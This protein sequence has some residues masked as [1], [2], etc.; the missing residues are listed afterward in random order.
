MLI[1]KMLIV[2][3]GLITLLSK[4]TNKLEELEEGEIG[5]NFVLEILNLTKFILPQSEILFRSEMMEV[6]KDTRE[7]ER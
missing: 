6:D 2:R 7:R 4:Q 3:E 1:P 5:M